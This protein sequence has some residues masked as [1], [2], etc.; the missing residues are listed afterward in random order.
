MTT[1]SQHVA[2]TIVQEL[3]TSEF[4][5]A[6]VLDRIL[7]LRE[8]QYPAMVLFIDLEKARA[9]LDVVNGVNDELE[10]SVATCHYNLIRYLDK[11]L[12]SNGRAIDLNADNCRLID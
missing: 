5:E 4:W 1:I 7:A 10:S 12:S 2:V 9:F 11:V 3:V 6:T 8:I